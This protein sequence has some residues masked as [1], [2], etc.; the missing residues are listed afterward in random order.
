MFFVTAACASTKPVDTAPITGVTGDSTITSTGDS[1][2]DS[3]TDSSPDSASDSACAT[4]TFYADNDGDGFGSDA[5]AVTVCDQ[6]AGYVLIGG[7]CDDA[8]PDIHPGVTEIE[9]DGIDQDCDGFDT[10]GT[11]PCVALGTVENPAETCQDLYNRAGALTGAYWI[12]P[13]GTGD[14]PV[15]EVWCDMKD[16]GGG[17]TLVLK[18]DASA[19][20]H[21]TTAAV[22][23]DELSNDSL[24]TVAKLDDAVVDAIIATSSAADEV[25]VDATGTSDTLIES[26]VTWAMYDN[27]AINRDLLGRL[28]SESTYSTGI[29]CYD[30]DAST[31]PPCSYDHWCIGKEGSEHACI[32]RWGTG[33][34]WMNWGIYPSGYYP[35]SV[36][37]R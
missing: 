29:V 9:G 25:R 6:P 35:A 2:S 7:D 19:P 12:D 24:D 37:V 16:D 8:N 17:W 1:T 32:R 30:G 15:F 10:C 13:D 23:P 4:S 18:T 36:W 28:G 33:G 26:G 5:T 3:P 14:I 31:N 20:T 34:I 27:G 21:Y 11:G 22:S